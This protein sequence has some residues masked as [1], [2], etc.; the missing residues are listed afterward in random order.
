[1]S[2]ALHCDPGPNGPEGNPGYFIPNNR[3]GRRASGLKGKKYKKQQQEEIKNEVAAYLVFSGVAPN[4]ACGVAIHEMFRK[5]S[6][7]ERRICDQ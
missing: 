3:E 5:E 7:N 4:K 1:M 2:G 6:R